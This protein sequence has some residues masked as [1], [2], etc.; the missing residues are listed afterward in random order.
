MRE[1][2]EQAEAFVGFESLKVNVDMGSVICMNSKFLPLDE[3]IVRTSMFD[4][5]KK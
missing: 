4:M 5:K 3:K 2:F 1:P